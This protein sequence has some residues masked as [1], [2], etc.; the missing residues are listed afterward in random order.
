MEPKPVLLPLALALGLVWW[1]GGGPT[2]VTV[3]LAP[4]AVE[5]SAGPLLSGVRGADS[6]ICDPLPPPTGNVVHVYPSQASQL[7]AVVAAATTGDTILLHDG[8][9]DLHGDYLW[10]DTPGVT[11][12]SASGNREAVV[13]DGHYETT[14]IVNVHASDVTIADLT[15]KRARDHPIHVVPPDDADIANTL[16]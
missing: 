8:T 13:I 1:L 14:E 7:D 2:P 12:R 10:F 5:G 6:T 16:I 11:M 4:R 9:Y 3:T 15:L